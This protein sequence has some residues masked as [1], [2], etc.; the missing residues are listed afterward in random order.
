M[1]TGMMI[2]GEYV[3]Y[4]T[5]YTQAIETKNLITIDLLKRVLY[6]YSIPQSI[7]LAD[8][9]C[10]HPYCQTHASILYLKQY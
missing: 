7:G 9:P 5:S 1:A 8:R 2:L 6:K 4:I 10:I 3:T